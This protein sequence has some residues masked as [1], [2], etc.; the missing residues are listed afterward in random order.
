MPLPKKRNSIGSP[1]SAALAG[2]LSSC[3]LARASSYELV[4]GFKRPI[5]AY[6]FSF[7]PSAERVGEAAVALRTPEYF[8]VLRAIQFLA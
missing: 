7:Y 4:V 5:D 6:K 3:R 2:D 1:P 8:E